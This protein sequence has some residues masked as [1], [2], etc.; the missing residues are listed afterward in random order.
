MGILTLDAARGASKGIFRTLIAALQLAR[1]RSIQTA[2]KEIGNSTA[3]LIIV[4]CDPKS[5]SHM[6][7]VIQSDAEQPAR[8][9]RETS[10]DIDRSALAVS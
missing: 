5:L 2:Q 8:T 3:K 4:Q 10:K 7:P 6:S 1:T 9:T